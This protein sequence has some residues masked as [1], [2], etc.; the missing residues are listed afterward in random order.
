[1]IGCAPGIQPRSRVRLVSGSRHGLTQS[2]ESRA[3][4]RHI[5]TELSD[6]PAIGY[7]TGILRNYAE[8]AERV[9]RLAARCANGSGL[10]PATASPSSPRTRRTIST[11]FMPSGTPGWSAV[12]ANAKLHG[13][14]LGYILEHSGARVALPRP[15]STARSRRMRRHRSSVVIAIGSAE[16]EALF[17]ADAIDVIAARR[18]RSRLAV[19]HLRH[20]RPAERRDADASQSRRQAHAYARRGRSASRPAIRSCMPRR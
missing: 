1:M 18:R 16:Y 8:L 3:A 7:G 4:S 13:A 15:A 20:D 11:R 10:R 6:R 19:L 12:P 2:D 17:A 14:E 5:G 9:A